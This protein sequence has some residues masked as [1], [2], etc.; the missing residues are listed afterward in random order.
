MAINTRKISG[1]SE[2]SEI[3]GSEY[4]ML[5]KNNRSYKAKAELFTSDKIKSIEQ[6]AAKGDDAISYINITTSAGENY[7]FTVKNGSK[8]SEGKIGK[9]GPKGETGDSGVILYN[10][11]MADII[12]DNLEGKNINGETYSDDELSTYILSARQGNILNGKIEALAEQYLTQDEYDFLVENNKIQD[13]VKY[14]IIEEE[15]EQ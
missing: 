4:I 13:H 5:A 6:T 3:T 12:V 2:L 11:D 1:L 8:G 7:T 10:T 15:N 9:P 14:F